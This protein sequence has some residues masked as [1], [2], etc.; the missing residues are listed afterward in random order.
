MMA[1]IKIG[2]ELARKFYISTN[3]KPAKSGDI[4]YVVDKKGKDS[5]PLLVQL[6]EIKVHIGGGDIYY[7]DLK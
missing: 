7:V 1:L 3:K 6:R 5:K 4:F 2:D